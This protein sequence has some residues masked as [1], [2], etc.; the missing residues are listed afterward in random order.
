MAKSGAV[1]GSIY[2]NSGQATAWA[3]RTRS[4]AATATVHAHTLWTRNRK[5][6]PMKDIVHF[7]G[8]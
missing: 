5:H 7:A 2:G 3:S 6:Y 1:P 8:M 4:S